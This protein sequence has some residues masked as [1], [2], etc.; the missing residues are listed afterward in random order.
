VVGAIVAGDAPRAAA[1]MRD[2]VLTV[3]DASLR[4]MRESQPIVWR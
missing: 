3:R 1:Q 4:F 2:H